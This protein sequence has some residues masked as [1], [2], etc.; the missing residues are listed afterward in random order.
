MSTTGPH[1]FSS[2]HSPS[3][4]DADGLCALVVGNI[5]DVATV[6]KVM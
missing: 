3:E 2:P 5:D 1:C 6:C 4:K